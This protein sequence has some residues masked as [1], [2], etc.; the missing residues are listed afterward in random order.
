MSVSDGLILSLQSRTVN[1]R[2]GE[3]QMNTFRNTSTAM[4]LGRPQLD[5]D[6]GPDWDDDGGIPEERA[7]LRAEC[8][9]EIELLEGSVSDLMDWFHEES[10]EFDAI[11]E[12]VAKA[13]EEKAQMDLERARFD[14]DFSPI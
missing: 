5:F 2:T 9:A 13:A 7:I 11:K 10:K 6:F 3:K 4:P 8:A 14:D 1:Q 12:L